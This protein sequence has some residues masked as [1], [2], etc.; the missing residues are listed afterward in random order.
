M[1]GRLEVAKKKNEKRGLRLKRKVRVRKKIVGDSTRPRLSVFRSS[2]QIYVQAI[3][4][5]KGV[6][7]SQACSLEKEA[8][9]SIRGMKKL[10]VAK[11]VGGLVGKRLV[12][13]GVEKVVFD[14]NGCRYEGRIAAVAEGAREAGLNF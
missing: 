12:A 7:I 5:A 14:R 10:E 2:E 3:D 6:T 11:V 13:A 8:K 9:A 1:K 4:D